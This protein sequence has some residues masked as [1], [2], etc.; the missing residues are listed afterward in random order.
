[1]KVKYLPIWAL[2]GA[3]AYELQI[4]RL[5]I[6]L[7]HLSGGYWSRFFCRARLTFRVWPN[8]SKAK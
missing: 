5:V 2:K 1:M 4:G 3:T 8:Q 6:R 7:C